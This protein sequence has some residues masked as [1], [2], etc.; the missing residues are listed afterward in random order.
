MVPK[1][2]TCLRPGCGGELTFSTKKGDYVCLDCKS[3]F[4]V[5]EVAGGGSSTLAPPFFGRDTERS[6]LLA[7]IQAAQAGRPQLV[8]VHGEPGMGKTSLIRNCYH[9]LAGPA[10]DPFDFWP[11]VV[12][13]LAELSA[14]DD[15]LLKKRI[16]LDPPFLWLAGQAPAPQSG[17]CMPL[18]PW[19]MAL[20]GLRNLPMEATGARLKGVALAVGAGLLDVGADL[21]GVGLVKTIVETAA[22]VNKALRKDGRASA[23]ITSVGGET[24]ESMKADIVRVM[25]QLATHPKIPLLIISLDDLHWADEATCNAMAAV[26]RAAKFGWRLLVVGGYR[27]NEVASEACAFAHTLPVLK[28]YSSDG[29]YALVDVGLGGL[30]PEAAAGLVRSHFPEAEKGLLAWLT[31][32][33]GSSP[34]YLHQFCALLNERGEVVHPGIVRPEGGV[35]QLKSMVASGVLPASLEAVLRERFNRLKAEQR[36]LLSF[37]SIQGRTFNDQYLSRVLSRLSGRAVSVDEIRVQLDDCERLHNL[38]RSAV[39]RSAIGWPYEFLHDLLHLTAGKLLS[40]AVRDTCL[41]ALKD[42][43]LDVWRDEDFGDLPLTQRRGVLQRLVALM[44]PEEGLPPELEEGESI[45]VFM[46]AASAAE[47]A[48]SKQEALSILGPLAE[49]LEHRVRGVGLQLIDWHLVV[50]Y[51]CQ[52]AG[53]L[54]SLGEIAEAFRKVEWAICL[55]RMGIDEVAKECSS[56]VPERTAD[57]DPLTAEDYDLIEQLLKL[58]LTNALELSADILKRQGELVEARS[59]L[60]LSIATLAE[61]CEAEPS[62][63]HS[64]AGTHESLGHVLSIMGLEGE[65]NEHY[66][67]AAEIRGEVLQSGKELDE[68]EKASLLASQAEDAERRERHEE[69]LELWQQCLAIRRKRL[70]EEANLARLNGVLQALEG[71]SDAYD[72]LERP[73][74]VA[75]VANRRLAEVAEHSVLLGSVAAAQARADANRDLAMAYSDLE[76]WPECLAASECA[77]RDYDEVMEAGGGESSLRASKAEALDLLADSLEYLDRP[78]EEMPIRQSAVAA[79]E[80]AFNEHG[81][82]LYRHELGCALFALGELL[83]EM[84]DSG[85]ALL[86]LRRAVVVGKEAHQ[87]DPNPVTALSLVKSLLSAGDLTNELDDE[88]ET[89][90]LWQ[91]ALEFALLAAGRWPGEF[92]TGV[93]DD[94]LY[95]NTLLAVEQKRWSEAEAHL[96]RWSEVRAQL[97]ADEREDLEE[98]FRRLR[99]E[100]RSK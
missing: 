67:R 37:A 32:D 51:F 46:D 45:R 95:R 78:A 65:A 36:Q 4:T 2:T 7:A 59:R 41:S 33:F 31:S 38:V 83:S 82:N 3:R 60:E 64:A 52:Y 74:Q 89:T 100:I 26:V 66:E 70:D 92:D 50:E 99:K 96:R 23:A 98:E 21:I 54:D 79:W 40:P 87:S 5:D 94:C 39:A 15:E 19:L 72:H 30:D 97:S 1:D 14:Q 20:E 55:G 25:G 8:L 47:D 18:H 42:W 16:G 88:R 13:E 44:P 28:R 91:A 58:S 75:D 29:N 63:H 22:G 76:R 9:S 6:M 77:C 85:E 12:G 57:Q 69:S 81:Q 43:L 49:H 11:D 68:E 62:L 17:A 35:A 90:S 93:L 48:G 73:K 10:Q 24:A 53:L 34:F 27:D 80:A 56:P 71:L 86:A 61:L 84:G